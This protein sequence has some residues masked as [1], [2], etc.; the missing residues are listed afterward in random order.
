MNSI[1]SYHELVG[2]EKQNFQ[3][4]MNYRCS[5]GYLELGIYRFDHIGYLNNDDFENLPDQTIYFDNITK[6]KP[7][8]EE[9]LKNK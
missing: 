7:K 6:R 4:G 1:I 2:I 9:S 3:R 5:K 8:K